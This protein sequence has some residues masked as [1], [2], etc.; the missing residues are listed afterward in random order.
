LLWNKKIRISSQWSPSVRAHCT[1]FFLIKCLQ[2]F[3]LKLRQFNGK[4][5]F[6]WRFKN[7]LWLCVSY[8]SF[9]AIIAEVI[10][11]YL[12]PH[13]YQWCPTYKPHNLTKDP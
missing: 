12:S 5:Y 9:S 1:G 2:W 7:V 13:M 11:N 10:S 8:S 3:F 4:I 6:N